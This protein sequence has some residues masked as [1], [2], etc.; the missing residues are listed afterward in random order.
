MRRCAEKA[1]I[2]A[3]RSAAAPVDEVARPGAGR[4]RRISSATITVLRHYAAALT[5]KPPRSDGRA[6][7]ACASNRQPTAERAKLALAA[8]EQQRS[9]EQQNAFL[10]AQISTKELDIKQLRQ[11]VETVEVGDSAIQLKAIPLLRRWTV[12]GAPPNE[13]KAGGLLERLARSDDP[14]VASAARKALVGV[15]DRSD[16]DRAKERLA[17]RR[18]VMP[19]LIELANDETQW[20]EGI[21]ALEV[22]YTCDDAETPKVAKA[23]LE[24]LKRS[25][26]PD[27][28]AAA[29]AAL[30]PKPKA[31]PESRQPTGLRPRAAPSVARCTFTIAA[32]WAG[33]AFDA[34]PRP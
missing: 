30:A 17:L 16:A 6:I 24:Q 15:H 18:K 13:Y 33:S 10:D 25:N 22:A 14:V 20:R 29:T 26:K 32:A 7:A 21:A 31:A 8:V 1:L 23:A 2:D 19:Y 9:N 4:P 28:A 11:I 34:P 3:G 27:V 5:L 12:A